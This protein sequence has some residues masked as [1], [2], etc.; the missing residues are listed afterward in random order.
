MYD[1]TESVYEGFLHYALQL[2]SLK[3]FDLWLVP[4]FLSPSASFSFFFPMVYDHQVVTSRGGFVF[5]RHGE[6]Y[7]SGHGSIEHGKSV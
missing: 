5:P 4:A 2:L 7:H 6:V 1:Y 3:I